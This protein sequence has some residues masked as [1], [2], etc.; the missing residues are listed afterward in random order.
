MN[1]F[2]Q[3]AE[4]SIH[5]RM[6]K[7]PL[8]AFCLLLFLFLYALSSVSKMTIEKQQESL[9]T[10]INRDIIHCYVVEGSYPSNLNYM[11]SHY[12]LTYDKDLFFVDYQPIASN[13]RPNVTVIQRSTTIPFLK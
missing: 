9:E 8:L 11:E 5:F 4:K 12:G 3:K 7:L 2:Q 10:A 6:F 1:R 13:I